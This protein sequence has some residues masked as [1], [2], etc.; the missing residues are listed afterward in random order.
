M[1]G[2]GGVPPGYERVRVRGAEIVARPALL[3]LMRQIITRTTLHEY[4]A[5]HPEARVMAGRVSV[6]AIPLGEHGERIV[7]RRAHHGGVLAGLT[8]DLFLRPRALEELAIA[9]RLAERGVPTPEIVACVLYRAGLFRR[10]DVATREVERASD[11]AAALMARPEPGPRKLLW[12][13]TARLVVQLVRAGARHPDLN[14]KNVLLAPGPTARVQAW[15]L[16]VDRVVF[17]TPG[18]A[19]IMAANIERLRRSARKWRDEHGAPI[20]E[21]D[22]EL[23]RAAVQREE[24]DRLR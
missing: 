19:G 23:L 3:P 17:G 24:R 16:D 14:L 12:D 2:G 18:D 9:L 10:S 8:R 1:I 4:A 7:V 22:L 20:D 13:A 6:H 11:L 15:V 21:T 5:A